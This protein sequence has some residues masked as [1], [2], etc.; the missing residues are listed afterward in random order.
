MRL[1]TRLMI[2][3]IYYLKTQNLNEIDF[4]N[5]IIDNSKIKKEKLN[6]RLLFID[7]NLFSLIDS[8][9]N[10]LI[11][12]IEFFIDIENN[13]SEPPEIIANKQIKQLEDDINQLN[14]VLI[15]KKLELQQTNEDLVKNYRLLEELYKAPRYGEYLITKEGNLVPF[16]NEEDIIKNEI[17]FLEENQQEL[18]KNYI[19][20]KSKY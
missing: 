11:N 16:N 12:K 10:N 14:D 6:S 19:I 1:T 17:S 13:F 9:K 15:N 3:L 7:D 5:S 18:E 2:Y 8:E 20:I 4:I